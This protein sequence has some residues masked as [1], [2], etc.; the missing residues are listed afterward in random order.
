MDFANDVG[1]FVAYAWGTKF[2]P[3]PEKMDIYTRF[4]LDGE[5]WMIRGAAFDYS[6]CGREITRQGK[7]GFRATG[8]PVR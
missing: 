2:Q 1:R 4:M 3:P 7:T 8:R 5:Q 6:A